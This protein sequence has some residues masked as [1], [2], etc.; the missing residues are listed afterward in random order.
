M[1]KFITAESIILIIAEFIIAE[2]IIA[3]FVTAEFIIA[4]FMIAEILKENV[5]G[6]GIA[7]ETVATAI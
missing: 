1:A 3:E 2:F 4:W 7:G 5:K 6:I